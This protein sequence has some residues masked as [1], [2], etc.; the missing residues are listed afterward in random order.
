M[1]LHC[2]VLVQLL[3]RRLIRTDRNGAVRR[4]L[5]PQ[6]QSRVA[7]ERKSEVVVRAERQTV[8]EP[9]IERHLEPVVLV[10][11]PRLLLVDRREAAERAQHVLRIGRRAGHA[12]RAECGILILR[13]IGRAD[14]DGVQIDGAV[15]SA[16]ERT[17]TIESVVADVRDVEYGVR[18]QPELHA[19][20]P[21][22]R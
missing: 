2:E 19:G 15:R 3:V 8:R 13:Q 22:P 18:R 1:P 9:A 14:V 12:A 10:P 7:F 20:L 5:Q 16:L 21:L 6:L 11:E 4:M 17:Q